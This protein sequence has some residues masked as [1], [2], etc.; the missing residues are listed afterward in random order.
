MEAALL[1]RDQPR[2]QAAVAGDHD[3]LPLRRLLGEAV[4]AACPWQSCA[5]LRL[6]WL[7][8]ARLP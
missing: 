2:E 6:A 3:L 1:D 5:E 4:H 7:D 8:G